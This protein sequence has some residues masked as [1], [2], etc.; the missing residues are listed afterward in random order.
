MLVTKIEPWS[1]YLN[2]NALFQLAITCLCNKMCQITNI[3]HFPKSFDKLK[4]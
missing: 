4:F 1:K 3:T 2:T